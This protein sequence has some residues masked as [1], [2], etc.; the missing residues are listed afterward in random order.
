[1]IEKLNKSNEQPRVNTKFYLLW[2]TWK[3]QLKWTHTC[4]H[5]L[6]HHYTFDVAKD[7]GILEASLAWASPV[8]ITWGIDMPPDITISVSRH[9]N[10]II[11]KINKPHFYQ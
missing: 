7:M 2:S 11:N 3:P 5:K 1:M 8:V 10:K 9:E 4:A 6:S